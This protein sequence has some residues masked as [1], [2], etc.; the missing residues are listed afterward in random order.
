MHREPPLDD[1][2]LTDFLT[3]LRSWGT[4][5]APEPSPAL[6]TLLVGVDRVDPVPPPARRTKMLVSKLAGFGIAAKVALGVGVAAAA[7]TTAGAV[8]VL[9][10]AAQHG[11]ATVV[12][13]VSPIEIPDV[14]ARLGADV[15]SDGGLD[16]DVTVPPTTVTLPAG[17][18]AD[19]ATDDDGAAAPDNHGACVSAAARDR[20][21]SGREHGQ[22]VSAIA[23][24]DCGKGDEGSTTSTTTVPG[25]EAGASGGNRGSGNA[26]GHANGN[27][28]NGNGKAG[29]GKG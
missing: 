4:D 28:G 29:S 25:D 1:P 7:V 16:A 10:D 5:E 20:S 8:G 14:S 3:E 9:P 6:A 11:V 21:L 2:F 12:N 23:Q 24:S 19:D 15:A 22:A 17:A 27:A 26:N 13:A 18:P